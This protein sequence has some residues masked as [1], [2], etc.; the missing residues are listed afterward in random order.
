MSYPLWLSLSPTLRQQRKQLVVASLPCFLV[1]TQKGICSVGFLRSFSAPQPGL[2]GP[3]RCVW[4]A[5]GSKQPVTAPSPGQ[6][7]R[8]KARP[9]PHLAG[10]AYK[11]LIFLR[12]QLHLK[13]TPWCD[14]PQRKLPKAWKWHQ[15]ITAWILEED[16][17]C[18]FVYFW[19]GLSKRQ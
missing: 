18:I 14:F 12:R 11:M 6:E 10:L 17:V 19:A 15:L 4:D 3:E 13:A 16:A 1:F 2:G 8:N 9:T 5:V 7:G